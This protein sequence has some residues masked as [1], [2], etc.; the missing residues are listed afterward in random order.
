MSSTKKK[1]RKK[2]KNPKKNPTRK[3]R[4][5][6]TPARIDVR[7]DAGSCP[8][9][10]VRV[11]KIAASTLE[12]ERRR[13]TISLYLTDDATI[14]KL[15]ALYLGRRRA[16]DVLAFPLDDATDSE[17]FLGEVVVSVETAHRRLTPRKKCRW[18]S[19]KN[20][21]GTY[22]KK[23][24]ESEIARYI[25]HGVLHLAGYRDSN[26]KSAALMH[27]REDRILRKLG[28]VLVSSEEIC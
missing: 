24:L 28:F 9:G 4:T 15:N 7:I 1:S 2:K 22:S 6:K 23:M 16:T 18:T 12:H 5:K 19:K 21:Y 25:I 13:G 10:P 14:R 3:K 20:K 8:L 27:K 11:R 17:N 26:E